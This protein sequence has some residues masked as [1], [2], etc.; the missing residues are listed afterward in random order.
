MIAT[1]ELGQQILDNLAESSEPPLNGSYRWM[2]VDQID[3]LERRIHRNRLRSSDDGGE[4]LSF[5]RPPLGNLSGVEQAASRATTAEQK[6]MAREDRRASWLLTIESVA[7]RLSRVSRHTATLVVWVGIAVSVGRL[8]IDPTLVSWLK[9]V[10]AGVLGNA[11][12]SG[13]GF[14]VLLVVAASLFRREI[15]RLLWHPKDSGDE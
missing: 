3:R 15:A 11:L 2:S 10:L 12:E 14:T 1:C 6:I 9:G 8:V 13:F 5:P 4:L 7:R